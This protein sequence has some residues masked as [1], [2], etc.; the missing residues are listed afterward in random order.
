VCSSDL[1]INYRIDKIAYLHDR[2][3]KVLTEYAKTKSGFGVIVTFMDTYFSPELK[4]IYGINS[5]KIVDLQKKYDFLLQPE[6]PQN[7]W[8]SEPTRYIELGNFYSKK[9][10]DPSKLLL[11]LNILSFREKNEVTP[12]PTEVQT[13]IE[14]YQ[15][16][17]SAAIGAPRFTVYSEATCNPQDIAFFSYASSSPVKY[18]NNDESYDVE[19]PYSFVIQLPKHI[20]IISVDNQTVVGYR[21]NKYII[22]AGKHNIEL[23]RTEIAGFS[24]AEL[25]PQILSF[26][27]NLTDITYGMQQ[28]VF[29]YE[30][31]ERSLVSLNRKPTSIKVDNINIDFEVLMGNDCFSVFLPSGKHTILITSGNSFS[32]GINLT[33]LWSS[34]AIALYGTIAII[35]LVIMYIFLKLFRRRFEKNK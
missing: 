14:S 31:S 21:D 10:T 30:S 18:K 33:S 25:Q 6:D 3:L 5:E 19:S 12:F 22:P 15:L 34:N 24:T 32:Y 17:R 23:H 29:N 16:I 7:K 20:K 28:L 27:G 1:V 13:G 11:D 35:L 8:S 9:M 2:F 4:E 26:T